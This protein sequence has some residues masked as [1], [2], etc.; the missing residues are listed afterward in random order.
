[1]SCGPAS[2]VNPPLYV[3]SLACVQ[4][5]CGKTPPFQSAASDAQFPQLY[6]RVLLVGSWKK[7][8][9]E[10]AFF[11]WKVPHVCSRLGAAL[12]RVSPQRPR[13]R[14]PAPRGG[15]Q[16]PSLIPTRSSRVE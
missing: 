15:L 11:L 10:S 6:V 12:A 8:H 1:M 16:P 13:P 5:L 9:P 7:G 3:L 4:L 14:A 2:A